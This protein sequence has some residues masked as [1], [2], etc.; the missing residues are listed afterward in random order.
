MNLHSWATTN[1]SATCDQAAK[2]PPHFDPGFF[3]CAEVLFLVRHQ[4]DREIYVGVQ[5]EPG[6]ME[7]GSD[8]DVERVRDD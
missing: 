3:G 8:S 6:I 1:K 5:V 4:M 2:S 7:S